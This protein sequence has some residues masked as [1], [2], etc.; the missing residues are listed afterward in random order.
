M[1]RDSRLHAPEI[2]RLL[3]QRSRALETVEAAGRKETQGESGRRNQGRSKRAFCFGG[4]IYALS[5]TGEGFLA[6][7]QLR[8]A[9]L[10]VIGSF[11]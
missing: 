8:R 7:G 3:I 4:K 9:A 1:V 11:V 2:A 5:Y 10:K 6:L